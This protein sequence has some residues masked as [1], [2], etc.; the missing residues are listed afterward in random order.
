MPMRSPVDEGAPMDAWT[1]SAG[2]SGGRIRFGIVGSG[3]RS[4][5]F[6][7]IAREM[8]DRFEVTGLVTRNEGTGRRIEKAWQVRPFASIDDLVATTSPSFV[9]VSVPREVAPGAIRHLAELKVP[10]LTETPPAPDLDALSSLYSLVGG[11]A[12]IQVAEQ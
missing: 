8:P 11:G 9:V 3:W 7:R 4:E 5:F 6:L 2:G 12:V 10:V 1:D